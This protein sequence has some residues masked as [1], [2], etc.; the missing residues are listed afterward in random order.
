MPQDPVVDRPAYKLF[1]PGSIGLVAFLAGPVGAFILLMLNYRRLG[2]RRAAWMTLAVSLLTV[3]LMVAINVAFPNPAPALLFAIALF[4]AL[5]VAARTLQGRAYD[6]HL[7]RGGEP[8]SGWAAAGFALLGLALC[9]VILLG[10]FVAYSFITSGG[11]GERIDFGGGEEIYYAE[12]ATEIDGRALGTFL[13]DVGFFNGQS[14]KT[15]RLS[16][17]GNRLVI[18]FVVQEWVLHDPR[19]LEEFRTIGQ[20]ASQ[21]AFRGRPV[22]VEL[23]DEYLEVQKRL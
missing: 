11:I 8:A 13:R 21:Q 5:V 19:A 2:E 10:S 20:R 9:F 4:V 16:V 7:Q 1:S 12:G 18:S 6:L 23:C 22:V 17:E 14:P 15:V 3:G